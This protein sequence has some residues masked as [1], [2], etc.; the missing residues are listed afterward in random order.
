MPLRSLGGGYWPGFQSMYNID[1]G[2][3]GAKTGFVF[4]GTSVLFI[5][6]LATFRVDRL[7]FTPPKTTRF[8]LLTQTLQ[9]PHILIAYR[10]G[11]FT[12][13]GRRPLECKWGHSVVYIIYALWPIII[14]P[15]VHLEKINTLFR[16]PKNSVTCECDNRNKRPNREGCSHG[17]SAW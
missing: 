2:N 15:S 13:E 5:P 12:L 17:W 16:Q 3:L 6:L 9:M 7:S 8:C 4:A 10:R 14:N 1:S 11:S